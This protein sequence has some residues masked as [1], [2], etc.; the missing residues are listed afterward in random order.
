MRVV[1]KS[2]AVEAALNSPLLVRSNQPPSGLSKMTL[3]F[4]GSHGIELER[5]DA[6][7][8]RQKERFVIERLQIDPVTVQQC[9][10]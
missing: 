1:T 10:E 5:L 2:R 3:F 6:T 8:S 7:I 4:F 9:T